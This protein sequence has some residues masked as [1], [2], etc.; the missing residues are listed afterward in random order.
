M[1]ILIS[2]NWLS[3][4]FS[5]AIALCTAAIVGWILISII[6]PNSLWWAIV[7]LASV[8]IYFVLSTFNSN[9]NLMYFFLSSS[10][11]GVLGVAII[12][13][14]KLKAKKNDDVH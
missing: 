14:L 13:I 3:V 10:K 4:G 6:S 5:I 1:N 12:A 9:E 8:C 11:G 2:D 7:F